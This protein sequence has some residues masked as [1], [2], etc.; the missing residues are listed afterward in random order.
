VSVLFHNT[1]ESWMA[2]QWHIWWSL[3]L[4]HFTHMAWGCWTGFS[5]LWL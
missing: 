5:S 1:I 2:V 4:R 3:C